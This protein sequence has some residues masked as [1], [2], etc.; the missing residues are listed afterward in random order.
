LVGTAVSR[1]HTYAFIS[2]KEQSE[3]EETRTKDRQITRVRAI[4]FSLLL[5]SCAS[6]AKELIQQKSEKN[7][8]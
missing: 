4:F 2:K 8:L 6:Q 7:A 3:K 1:R 5:T